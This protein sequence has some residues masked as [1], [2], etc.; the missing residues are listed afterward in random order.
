MLRG[1]LGGDAAALEATDELEGH[2]VVDGADGHRP[3]AG[4]QVAGDDG[5][6]ALSGPGLAVGDGGEPLLGP[7]LE[8]LVP[9]PGVDPV[10]AQQVGLDAGGEALGVDLTAE[11]LL[12]LPA[13]LVAVADVPAGL[14]GGGSSAL[15]VSHRRPPGAL[16]V[17]AGNRDD[18]VDPAGLDPGLD[19]V[20]VEAQQAANLAVRDAALLDQAADVALADSEATRQLVESDQRGWRRRG[21]GCPTANGV[22]AEEPKPP[23]PHAA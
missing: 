10:A 23:E 12:A 1:R 9:P 22:A 4:Q 7:G 2:R 16:P 5:F 19:L 13:G 3:E 21:H 20:G 8:G 14:P 18:G 6:V 17:G 11:A 15:E